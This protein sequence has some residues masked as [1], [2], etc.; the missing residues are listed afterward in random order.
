[1][2]VLRLSNRTQRFVIRENCVIMPSFQFVPFIE[3]EYNFC[4]AILNQYRFKAKLR[5][6]L[7]GNF[8][9]SNCYYK[10]YIAQHKTTNQ[11]ALV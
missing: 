4:I 10:A 5:T 6:K 7:I 9:E 2:V 8:F 1:M 11:M 3:T